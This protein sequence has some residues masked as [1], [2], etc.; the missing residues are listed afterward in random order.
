VLAGPIRWELYKTIKRPAVWVL[1]GL[2]FALLFLFGYL[3][4]WYLLS[5]PPAGLQ[6]PHGGALLKLKQGLYPQ[7]FVSTALQ[8]GGIPNTIVLIFGV[9]A[10]GSEYGWG[11]LKTLLTQRPGRFQALAVKLIALLIS[12]VVASA[13]YLVVAAI[14]SLVFAALDSH[15]VAW[16][17]IEDVITGFSALIL[18]WAFWALFGAMLAILFRQAALAVG[19]GFA[20]MFLVEG[21]LLGLG[22]SF[23]GGLF[24]DLQ[25]AFPGANA[26]S[27]A[28]SFGPL[29]PIRTLG[30]A[31]QAIVNAEQATLVLLAYCVGS[32][33]I[34]V[35]LF[36]RDVQ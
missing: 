24:H 13:L 23:G 9:L 8:Q 19:L 30:S 14:S 20:Y 29:P 34:S 15:P 1:A 27:L 3:L 32:V 26:G 18:I 12:V 5:H 36:R 21:L 25:K 11:T 31:T 16:P 22:A 4:G 6:I 2:L 10:V 35:A 7:H 33:A 17:T 28:M